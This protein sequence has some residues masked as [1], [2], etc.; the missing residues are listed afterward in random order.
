MRPTQDFLRM[1]LV[2][3]CLVV[4]AAF[5][6]SEWTNRTGDTLLGYVMSDQ[7]A[8]YAVA[9]V[10]PQQAVKQVEQE[11]PLDALPETSHA[12]FLSLFLHDDWQERPDEVQLVTWFSTEPRLKSLKAQM[13][14]RLYTP[15]NPL[16]AA[17]YAKSF[18]SLPGVM[19]QKSDGNAIYKVGSSIPIPQTAGGLA[20]RIIEAIKERFP[21]CRPRPKPTPVPDETPKPSPNVIPDM[22][23]IPDTIVDVVDVEPE[24]AGLSTGSKL[25]IGGLLLVV[26]A[27][28][29]A[30]VA[31][32]KDAGL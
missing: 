18:P 15:S 8:S 12:W 5:I 28:G 26:A 14:T 3:C 1:L 22:P 20:N 6:G 13:H 16:F 10:V 19:L 17:R 11:I 32:K 30:L 23:V 4:A 21:D 31:A 27:I 7:S 24:E 2:C 9:S 25:A 29:A